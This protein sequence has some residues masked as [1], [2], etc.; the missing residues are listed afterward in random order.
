MKKMIIV[1]VSFFKTFG[2]NNVLITI[3]NS[4]EGN[5]LLPS[6]PRFKSC[7]NFHVVNGVC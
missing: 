2:I 4:F 1:K 7:E 6:S 5:G 3:L